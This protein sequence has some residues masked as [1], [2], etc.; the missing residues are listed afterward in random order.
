MKIVFTCPMNGRKYRL[1]RMNDLCWTID[2]QPL[3]GIARNGQKV[4]RE[5]V[6]QDTYPSTL[7]GG[8]LAVVKRMLLDASNDEVT[9]EL[10]PDSKATIEQQV[11]RVVDSTERFIKAIRTEIEK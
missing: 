8:I 5:W 11:A 7:E 1:R 4:K 2:R 9:Y 10:S 6:N 3:P